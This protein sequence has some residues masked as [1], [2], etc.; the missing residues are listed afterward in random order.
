MPP[1]H[2]LV[3]VLLVLSACAEDEKSC[4]DR[5]MA[6]FDKEADLANEMGNHEYALTAR[7]SAVTATVIYGD[8]DRSI[9]DYV[10]AGPRLERK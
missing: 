1:R 2:L 9:C 7:E 6:D 4:Y 3:F 8:D 5:I 10:T